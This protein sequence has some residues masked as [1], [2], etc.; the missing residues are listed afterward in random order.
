MRG[1]VTWFPPMLF[2]GLL[3]TFATVAQFLPRPL[4]PGRL[5]NIAGMGLLLLFPF[6]VIRPFVIRWI[7]RRTEQAID[8]CV[9]NADELVRLE[10]GRIN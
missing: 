5:V 10:Q 2:G 3:I 7:R 6:V 1:F 4:P 8:A 9:R